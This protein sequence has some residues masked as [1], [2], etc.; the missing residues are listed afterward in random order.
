MVQF[1]T[2][3]P[4]TREQENKGAGHCWA[5]RRAGR[6]RR[7]C[8]WGILVL[9]SKKEKS[10]A[11]NRGRAEYLTYIYT[12]RRARRQTRRDMQIAC[13]QYTFRSLA[14]ERRRH[15]F[16]HVRFVGI[17]RGKESGGGHASLW[18]FVS[19]GEEREER[20]RTWPRSWEV[21]DSKGRGVWWEEDKSERV[22]RYA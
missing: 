3:F 5:F 18:M 10:G 21:L 2:N 9:I 6:R 19:E 20:K 15:V 17:E 16:L 8:L 1:C 4:V 12:P 22:Q 14:D 11:V 7:T 13:N